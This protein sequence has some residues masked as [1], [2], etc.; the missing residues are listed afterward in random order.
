MMALVPRA[1]SS[2][3]KCCSYH[4]VPHV[5]FAFLCYSCDMLEIL[6]LQP[7]PKGCWEKANSL[8]GPSADWNPWRWHG[9][10]GNGPLGKVVSKE[11]TWG[12]P[13]KHQCKHLTVTIQGPPGQSQSLWGVQTLLCSVSLFKTPRL[14]S[15]PAYGKEWTFAEPETLQSWFHVILTASLQVGTRRS[16]WTSYKTL[17]KLL[18][19]PCL[20]FLTCEH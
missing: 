3:A 5:A 6:K 11:S 2:C 12:V 10:L 18:S 13:P 8:F 9:S 16:P 1:S 4:A 19:H 7:R 15:W 17:N 20:R 14:T